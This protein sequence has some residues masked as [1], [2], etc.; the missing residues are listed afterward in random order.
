[1]SNPVNPAG[2]YKRQ[3]YI[4][5]TVETKRTGTRKSRSSEQKDS[6]SDDRVS[7][8]DT[9]KKM[10][11]AKTA[12]ASASGNNDEVERAER[13]KQ[14]KRDIEEGR[15]QVDAEKIAEKLINTLIDD[16]I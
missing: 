9:S 6:V 5:E 4:N 16:F 15:Y 11:T 1:M 8:S 13:I 2:N 3:S 14:I 10:R 12:M 7:L